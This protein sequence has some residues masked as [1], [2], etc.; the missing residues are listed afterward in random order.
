ML[1][2]PYLF[3]WIVT[4]FKAESSTI[5]E[6]VSMLGWLGASQFS[7]LVLCLYGLKSEMRDRFASRNLSSFPPYV[8]IPLIVS[9]SAAIVGF[10]TIVQKLSEEMP[11]M[12]CQSI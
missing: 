5:F 2:T 12:K 9:A 8:L 7:G 1:A 10:V 4:K 3:I 11:I 6:R